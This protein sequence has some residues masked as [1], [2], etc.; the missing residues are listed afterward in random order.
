[1]TARTMRGQ[2]AVAGIGHTTYY[3]HGQSPDNEFVMAMKAILAACADAGLSPRE[4]DGFASFG[5]ERNDPVRLAAAL[6]INELRFSNMQ[7]RGGGGGCAGAIA[8]AAAAVS[9]GL[10][11][12]VIVH[13]ALCQ[14]AFGRYGQAGGYGAIAGEA[15]FE[16]PY[17]LFTFAQKGAI[18][19]NRFMHD[20]N[21]GTETLFNVAMASY[22]HAQSNPD[23]V[24]YGKPLTRDRYE[25]ARMIAEPFRLFDCCMENDVAVAVL[26]VSA[27][28]ARHL[29][30]APAYILG[31]ASGAGH[32]ATTG[33]FG[34]PDYASS[35]TAPVAR[36]VYDM[37][38]VGPADVGS[39]QAYENFTGAVVMSLADHGF[40]ARE[41]AEDFLQLG[42]LIAPEGK[43]PINTAGGNLAECYSHGLGL[44]LEAVRQIRGTAR[45][46]ARRSEVALMIGGPM[47]TP[48]SSV[49]FGAEA[50]L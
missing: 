11:D 7:W 1:M 17:G 37:A 21:I 24:M 41:D 9:S 39:V 47:V 45:C 32:M 2:A 25:A 44:A 50:T 29:R 30:R 18:R 49:I 42:N 20:Y 36:R 40:Y 8:N 33:L 15:N 12:C 43:L 28:K 19:F 34:D 16:A 10:A 22:H 31:A 48:T 14:G 27:H 23:A 6:G 35:A 3:K 13:R 38:Q 4:I 46:Q 5:N 26:V